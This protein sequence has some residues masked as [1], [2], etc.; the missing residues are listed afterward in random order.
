LIFNFAYLIKYGWK[1]NCEGLQYECYSNCVLFY[2]TSISD[3]IPM[4][5]FAN[6]ISLCSSLE[7]I[8]QFHI[9]THRTVTM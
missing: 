5:L 4:S 6:T 9:H 8:Y 3:V 7:I 1:S 2:F